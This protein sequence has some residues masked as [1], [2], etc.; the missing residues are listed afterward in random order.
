MCWDYENKYGNRCFDLF[1]EGWEDDSSPVDILE[2]Y[3]IEMVDKNR[4]ESEFLELLTV[5]FVL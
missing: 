3:N 5:L 4:F 1:F 2:K